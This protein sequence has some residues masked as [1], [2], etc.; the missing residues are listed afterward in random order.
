MSAVIVCAIRM[1]FFYPH[2]I[3]PFSFAGNIF[4]FLIKECFLPA[5]I[6]YVVFFIVSKDTL[7]YKINGI[8]PL[9]LSFYVVYFPYAVINSSSGFMEPFSLILKPI[10]Y[11]AMFG[12]VGIMAREMYRL[13]KS[14]KKIWLVVIYSLLILV[15]MVGPAVIES[16]YLMNTKFWMAFLCTLCYVAYP[17][18]YCIFKVIKIVNNF[19]NNGD[20][21]FNSGFGSISSSRGGSN[22]K[23]ES[24]SDLGFGSS[25]GLNSGSSSKSNFSFD[26]S[27]HKNFFDK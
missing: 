23:T 10:I 25:S 13:C 19:N 11:V 24:S 6:L 8:F 17:C 18:V 9:E 14:K 15:Y 2:R 16:L 5:V 3:V 27:S 20:S 21:Y 7:E 1:I 26:S 4:Y 22:S 12:A